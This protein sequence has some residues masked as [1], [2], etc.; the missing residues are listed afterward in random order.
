MKKSKAFMLVLIIAAVIVA[1]QYL[2][3]PQ[4]VADQPKKFT[5]GQQL[6][7]YIKSG[8]LMA[9]MG[10]NPVWGGAPRAMLKEAAAPSMNQAQG[11][12]KS[13]DS[14]ST[15]NVQVEGVDE[16]DIMKNDGKYL[17]VAAANK[18]NILEAYPAEG[19]RILSSI[20]C[21]GPPVG[22]YV[23]GDRL[24]VI[25]NRSNYTGLMAAV[26]DIADRAKPVVVRTLSWEGGYV[27]SRLIGDYAYLVV[28]M[29]VEDGVITPTLIEN[30][31]KR[32]IPP[33]DIY[34]FDYPD[35]DY[36]YTLIVSVNLADSKREALYKTFLTG[37]SQN[38]YCSA[39]NLY[40][41]G[42]KIPD[43]VFYMNQFISGLASLV[44]G[45]ASA[46]VE[47][48]ASSDSSPDKKMMEAEQV[49]EEYMGGLDYSS[50]ADLED[51]ISQLREK[52]SR[53]MN[54]ERN[55]TVI[56]KIGVKEGIVEYKCRGEVNGR[57]LNQ[58]SMDEEGGYFRV[59][60]TSEGFLFTDR[61]VTR[62][63]IY[64]MD[65][66][67]KVVGRLEGLAP[68]E[69]IYSA[70]FMGGRVYLVTFRNIDP[71]FVIDLKDPSN[72]KVLGELKIPGFSDYLHPYD[73]N[74]IIG[75]G[76]EVAPAPEPQPVPLG[77]N[78][79]RT[80][81]QIMPPLPSRPQGVKIALFDVTNPEKPVEMSK[82]VV[83][84]LYS[85]SEALR[86][87]RAF[88]F[89]REKNLMALPISY[90]INDPLPKRP[91][92]IP[93]YGYW[94]GMYVFNISPEGGIG[95]R[96]KVVHPAAGMQGSENQPEAVRRAA[97][98]NDIF[99]TVSDGAVKMSRLDN[100][101]EVKVIR[102]P[103]DNIYYYGPQPE[104]RK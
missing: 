51:K 58:F 85:D 40:L 11:M 83:E 65:Q 73:E 7:N 44:S 26:Y 102:L 88:L 104:Y 60:T 27:S 32:L 42:E 94:Q 64:V 77:P 29:P 59:A 63:N 66:G 61:P 54:R 101:K 43:A 30:G 97:Y 39:E 17:Y 57:L 19:A 31:I 14:H 79:Q 16:D 24:M 45:E 3:P 70:R 98:I 25:S 103:R 78:G 18:V 33:S 23:K 35:F 81:L 95:L 56:H 2:N 4:S 15:T 12:A 86:E 37:F 92:V 55:K 75:V 87:H 20:S 13:E 36:R 21:E 68:R 52:L 53:D 38:I 1:G 84:N 48:I 80:Q 34:Y 50:A 49:L 62:N 74:H 89:S 22:I 9:Q 6:V 82:Y 67:L 69:R 28:N 96:G 100:L 76:K 71:L 41:T 10:D 8:R 46:K 93:Y 90:T 47:G 72:P 5:D 91:G 99:Y